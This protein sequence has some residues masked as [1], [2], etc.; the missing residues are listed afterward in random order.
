MVKEFDKIRGSIE[1]EGN[2]SELLKELREE[3]LEELESIK[4]NKLWEEYEEE[5]V[6]NFDEEIK[7]EHGNS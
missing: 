5:A 2:G 7:N 6:K 3:E 1:Y 4:E